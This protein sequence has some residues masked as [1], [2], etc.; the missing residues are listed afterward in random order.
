[1]F[2]HSYYPEES[3]DD[4][5]P[6]RVDNRKKPIR[7]S[8]V[9]SVAPILHLFGLNICE[10][11]STGKFF[12]VCL[13]LTISEFVEMCETLCGALIVATRWKIG[14][15]N[16]DEFSFSLTFRKQAFQHYY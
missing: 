12:C 5:G 6:V 4:C 7:V 8:H 15:V 2:L 10:P 3:D 1:M 11:C 16:F 13:L 14:N 9:L